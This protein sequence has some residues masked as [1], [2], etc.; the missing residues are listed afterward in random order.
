MKP[1]NLLTSTI[2]ILLMNVLMTGLFAQEWEWTD[3]LPVSDSI[4]DNRNALLK[5]VVF[6]G[7]YAYMLFWERSEVPGSTSIY[8]RNIYEMDDPALIVPGENFHCTNPRIINTYLYDNDTLFY[9]FYESDQNGNSDIYYKIYIIDGFSEPVLFAGSEADESHFRVNNTG[10]MTWQE[11]D[12]IK[13]AHLYKYNSP[14]IITDPVTID[15]VNCSSPD[16]ILGE[17]FY[18]SY[19]AY[20]KTGNDSTFIFLDYW[21][22]SMPEPQLLTGAAE[23]TSLRAATGTCG[24]EAPVIGWESIENGVHTVHAMTTN[25]GE[26]F[27]SEFRQNSPFNPSMAIYYVPVLFLYE[28]GFLTFTYG[29]EQENDVYVNTD[30]F[31]FSPVIED[32]TNLSAS[33][34][35]ESNPVLFQGEFLSYP[36]RDMCI[37][38]ESQLNGHWQLFY[39][40]KE[41]FC[42]GSISEQQNTVISGLNIYPNPVY[43][44][45]EINYTLSE[46]S[47]V[48]IQLFSSDGK[49]VKLLDNTFQDPGEQSFQLD[50]RKIFPGNSVTRLYLL[51]VTAGQHVVSG[52][53]ILSR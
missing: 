18:D 47:P 28:S 8:C 38:W 19:I 45:C 50:L 51:N 9:L 3:P 32:Y 44:T 53:I 16:I 17:S 42:G 30:E 35:I 24:D 48:L 11:G 40:H 33:P 20:L 37:I 7:N 36:Y 21:D 4:S 49:Q 15:S 26:E 52:K 1:D 25:A 34:N 22:G 29:S 14:F 6:N 41:I 27:I 31:Q 39:T 2:F 46:R 12:K 23:I 43:N 5:D 13:S 10:V